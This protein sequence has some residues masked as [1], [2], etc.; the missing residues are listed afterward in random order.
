MKNKI[1]VVVAIL[2]LLGMFSITISLND[3]FFTTKFYSE[4]LS[5]YNEDATYDPIY[6]D[7]VANKT[8]G[9]LKIDEENVLFIGELSQV[10]FLIAEMMVKDNKYAYKGTVSFYDSSDQFNKHI[11]NQTKTKTGNVKWQVFTNKQEVEKIQNIKSVNEYF[12]SNG[13]SLFIVILDE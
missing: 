10:E 4:P 7:T 5:A 3:F 2:V 9:L 13:S 8:I 6:G 11:Y 12:L 1:I